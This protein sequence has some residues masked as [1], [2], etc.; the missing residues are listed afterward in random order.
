MGHTAVE[1]LPVPLLALL[2]KQHAPEQSCAAMRCYSGTIAF[3]LYQQEK[4]GKKVF[5]L[6][7]LVDTLSTASRKL[8]CQ[9]DS[10]TEATSFFL[11]LCVF[12]S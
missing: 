1:R 8:F 5:W 7:C 9:R 2:A 12:T 6:A 10:Q 11:F 4:A 3:H